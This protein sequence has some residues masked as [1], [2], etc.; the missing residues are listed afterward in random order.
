MNNFI[1]YKYNSIIPSDL[2]SKNILM[3]GRS[4]N[5]Y[6]RFDIA[7]K[8]M[9]YISQEI[10]GC[11]MKIIS[12]GTLELQN[13]IN[14]LNLENF[15]HFFGFSLTPEI[16]FKNISLHIFPTISESFG[17]VLS[18]TKIFG[19]PN[20]LL[21]LDYVSISKGG[22]FIIYDDTPESIG[23]EAIKLLKNYKYRKFL[24]L[25]A[26]KSM[27]N[28]NNDLLFNKWIKLILSIYNNDIYY[29]LIINEQRKMK[30]KEALIIL[31][32][33]IN[34]IKI[35][36][37]IYANITI[38]DITNFSKISMLDIIGS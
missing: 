25:E 20:I 32:R 1:T 30:E 18:E 8:S 22:T 12:N 38:N 23:K 29:K 36:K 4:N 24:G 7:I 2:S 17:L 13:L 37:S 21:G 11:K 5:K 19:I 26:K 16:Y 6:K 33:Q 15:V 31:K 27:K 10:K 35:R 9:E 3:I 34:L 28:Y 14:S